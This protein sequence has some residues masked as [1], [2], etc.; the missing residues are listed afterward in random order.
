MKLSLL[1]FFILAFT[2][3]LFAQ[4]QLEQ[5]IS[6][7]LG[8]RYSGG[9]NPHEYEKF[10]YLGLFKNEESYFL[11]PTRIKVETSYDKCSGDSIFETKAVSSGE[12]LFL[13]WGLPQYSSNAIQTHYIA[14]HRRFV[15]P[16][17]NYIFSFSK[18]H[19]AFRGY[20]ESVGNSV[21]N[22][23]LK[24]INETLNREQIL[25]DEEY[26]DDSKVDILFIGDLDGDDKPD[27]IINAPPS[28]DTRNVMLFLS[29]YAEKGELV[30][31]VSQQF[32]WFDC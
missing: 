22:Y 29:S 31:C 14:D 17:K 15:P 11:K 9:V 18:E 3:N 16:N 8:H 26:L 4:T 19:Y 2:L 1:S 32:D 30:H 21:N 5:K 20:G 10:T 7:L 24:L 25:I 13:L 23:K 27:I 6:I 12:C 28:K